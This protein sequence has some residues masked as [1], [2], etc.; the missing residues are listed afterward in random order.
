[1]DSSAPQAPLVAIWRALCRHFGARRE[2]RREPIVSRPAL[3][4]FVDTRAT[5]MAQSSLY[6]YLRTRTG[7]RYPELFSDDVFVVALNVAKWHIWLDC[8]ADLAIYSGGLLLR[9]PSATPESVAD[10]M[11]ALVDVILDEHGVPDGAG[12]EFPAHAE[13]V[14]QRLRNCDWTAVS[15]DEGPFSE[16]PRSLVRW[17]PIID[18]LKELDEEIVINSVR[19]R[20]QEVRRELRATL[21]A[22][23]VLHDTG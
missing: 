18:E 9:E 17:A 20:W 15:D 19:F 12:E 11:P 7:M 22:G 14:R 1:M 5:H 4:R 8:V 6:G 2:H 16:S 23:A 10:L 3:A 21:D 13:R